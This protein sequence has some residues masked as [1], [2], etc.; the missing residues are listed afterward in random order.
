MSDERPLWRLSNPP[1]QVEREGSH[2]GGGSDGVRHYGNIGG[3]EFMAVNGVRFSDRV[4]WRRTIGLWTRFRA[5]RP[6]DELLRQDLPTLGGIPLTHLKGY[7]G[8]NTVHVLHKM[9]SAM[10]AT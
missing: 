3:R 1:A 2:V 10:T 4:R 7:E 8:L 5:D 6:A 9:R